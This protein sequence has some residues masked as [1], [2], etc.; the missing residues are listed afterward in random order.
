M[1]SE[2]LLQ[3]LSYLSTT[4]NVASSQEIADELNI[5]LSTLYRHL[6]LLR[7]WGFIADGEE[8]N[9]ITIGAIGLQMAERYL[10]HSLLI[11]ISRPDLMQLATK[12]QE[13][14]AL[15]VLS[16]HQAV[17]VD[18]IESRQA[19]RCSF[20]VGKAQ[21][22]HRGASAKALL[23]FMDEQSRQAVMQH[24]ISETTHKKQLS[25]QLNIIKNQG[26][27][28][29]RSEVD[30]GIWGVSVPIFKKNILQ[31]GLSIMAPEM[32]MTHKENIL[33]EAAVQ[34]ASSITE[35]FNLH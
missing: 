31:G 20:A 22:L 27:A 18:M 24:L 9:T 2:R 11:E 1:S 3:I 17:C 33:I 32:R 8:K 6:H 34:A 26:F 29:S 12:T 10:Q 14:V 28:I 5:P 21:P 7:K 19:L 25:E 30:Y 35:Y 23:A 4:E 16:H 15:M 13:T